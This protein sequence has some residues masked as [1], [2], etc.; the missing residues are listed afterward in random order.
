M[1]G[2]ESVRNQRQFVSP[3]PIDRRLADTCSGGDRFDPER[4]VPD[5]AQLV[6]CSLQG[7][8]AGSVHAGGDGPSGGLGVVQSRD[9]QL[10]LGGTEPGYCSDTLTYLYETLTF[11]RRLWIKE[12]RHG[13]CKCPIHRERRRRGDRLLLRAPRLP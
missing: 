7:D 10:L 4:A 6:E 3:V 2:L 11:Y 1:E 5:F 8:P 12:N 9:R 13:D